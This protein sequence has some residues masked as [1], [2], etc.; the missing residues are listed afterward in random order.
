[1]LNYIQFKHS[2]LLTA[3]P[4]LKTMGEADSI[5][6]GTVRVKSPSERNGFLS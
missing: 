6:E 2:T 3:A 1:M 4:T 5:G